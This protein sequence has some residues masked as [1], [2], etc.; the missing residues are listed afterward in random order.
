MTGLAP[1]CL[2]L[3]PSLPAG[4]PASQPAGQPASL[5]ASQLPAWILHS[6]RRPPQPRRWWLG[7]LSPERKRSD[8][9]QDSGSTNGPSSL[10]APSLATGRAEERWTW[11]SHSYG[12]L[13]SP[14]P[15]PS[16][17]P[18]PSFVSCPYP[19]ASRGQS[20]I[21]PLLRAHLRSLSIVARSGGARPLR[22]FPTLHHTPSIVIAQLIT[23]LVEGNLAIALGLLV[24]AS[25]P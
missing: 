24:L 11:Y 13:P 10:P 23:S 8:S 15:S 6:Y 22:T 5:P 25:N 21:F 14:S 7:S 9:D 16:P 19:K 3:T 1:P 18:A 17:S 12:T 2:T 20:T 4:Q